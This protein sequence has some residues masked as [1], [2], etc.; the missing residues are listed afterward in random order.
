MSSR[1]RRVLQLVEGAVAVAY[2]LEY[3]IVSAEVAKLV[4]E[5]ILGFF[6]EKS[7]I[8]ELLFCIL[9]WR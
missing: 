9:L 8:E 4:A 2:R 3:C 7:S 1:A 5:Q 6:V